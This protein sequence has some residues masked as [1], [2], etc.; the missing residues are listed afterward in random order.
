MSFSASGLSRA[1]TSVH[2]SAM[3]A[4]MMHIRRRNICAV[5]GRLTLHVVTELAEFTGHLKVET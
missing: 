4:R 5:V 1:L 2:I 3:P